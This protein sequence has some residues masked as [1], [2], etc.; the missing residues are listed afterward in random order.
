MKKFIKQGYLIPSRVMHGIWFLD[1]PKDLCR[2][3]WSKLCATSRNS[4]W[5]IT[6]RTIFN[7]GVR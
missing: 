6:S 4:N 2:S 1:P 7:N 5:R 3:K